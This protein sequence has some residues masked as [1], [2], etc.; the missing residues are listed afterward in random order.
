MLRLGRQNVDIPAGVSD[1]RVSDTFVLPVDAEVRAIQPHAHYRARS[2]SAWATLPG[3]ARRQLIAIG[4]WDFNWQDQ[5][6]Y[7]APFWLPAGTTIAMEYVF[8]NSDANP[9][10]PDHPPRRVSWGWRTSDEMA[11]VWIQ[12]V[13]RSAADRARLA[14]DARRTMAAEDVVGC[15]VLIAREPEYAAVRNDAAALY[16]ELGQPARALQHF[17]VVRRL[18][19]QSAVARYNVGVALEASGRAADAAREYEAAI[20]LEPAYSLAHNNLGSLRLSAGRLEEARRQFE[21]AVESGPQNAEA[22]NNLGAVVLA[23]GDAQGAVRFLEAAV[24]LRPDYPEAHFNLAR[25]FAVSGRTADAKREA[26]TAEAQ[27]ASAG[28]TELVAAIRD[29]F[30]R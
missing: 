21:A 5:Y 18:Q 19:P 3:G 11:D 29:Q 17:E 4:Q 6:R 12:M 27:A 24:R 26:A 2:I 25:A 15:E 10:N 7:A 30:R 23:S 1:Y 9:R 16:M 14:A 20:R 22:H 8:D 13:T 28:K